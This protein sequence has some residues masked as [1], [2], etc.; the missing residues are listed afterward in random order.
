M[1]RSFDLVL[2]GKLSN[3]LKMKSLILP[4]FKKKGK[5]SF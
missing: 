4:D 1:E 3:F 5:L 2:K